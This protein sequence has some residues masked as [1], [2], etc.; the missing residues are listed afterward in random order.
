MCKDYIPASNA[1]CVFHDKV[2]YGQVEY[3]KSA[4]K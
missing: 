1:L 4:E 2:E 3:R